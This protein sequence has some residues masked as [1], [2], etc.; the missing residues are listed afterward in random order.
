MWN[1]RD[2]KVK[3]IKKHGRKSPEKQP[4]EMNEN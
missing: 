4:N 3:R 2:Q 1:L